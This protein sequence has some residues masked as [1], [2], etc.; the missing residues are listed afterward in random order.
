[1][2]IVRRGL[3]IDTRCPMC[4]RL[5]E[6]GGHFFLKCKMVKKCWQ[7]LLLEDVRVYLLTLGSA[8][9]VVGHILR[10]SR[11]KQQLII[12]LLWAWWLG[13][14]KANAGE[15]A[16][17]V[18]EIANRA[19][20]LASEVFRSQQATTNT[21]REAMKDCH[22]WSPPPV[23][24]LKI[25]SDGA[26][27]E[28]EKTGAWGFVVRDSDG[29]SVLAGSGYLPAIHDALSA[30]GEAC[31]A[32][33]K[34]MMEAGI[35]RVIIEADSINLLSAIQTASFDQ[36]PGSIIFR[37]IREFL[38]L[39]FVSVKFSFVPRSCNRGAHELAQA[40]FERDPGQPFI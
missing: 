11:E 23:D 22:R 27:H 21:S 1:M 34:T 9:E 10:L 31:L 20:V 16:P 18:F 3:E 36:A 25:N 19:S 7:H 8:K 24:V 12:C 6:D 40:G 2:N 14:N 26:F 39:H 37:E 35:S 38:S 30:E 17:S 4:W 28:K 33:L 15:R 13:R 29:H 5:D 32:A